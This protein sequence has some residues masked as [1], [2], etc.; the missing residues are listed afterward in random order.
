MQTVLA[1]D[2]PW[3]MG[4]KCMNETKR[5]AKRYHE[6][7]SFMKTL[8]YRNT[9]SQMQ[10]V[11]ENITVQKRYHECRSFMKTLQYRN[12]VSRMQI[13]HA[14]ITVQQVI[15]HSKKYSRT[16]TVS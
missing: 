13:V 9:V 10:I 8:Q 2:G 4:D 14:N 1:A 6:C 11:H 16:K 5:R 15:Q 12:T 7:R 3:C